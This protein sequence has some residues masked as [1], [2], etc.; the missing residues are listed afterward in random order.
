MFKIIV[1]EN[2]DELSEK[3]FEVMKE[4]ITSSPI[5]FWVWRQAPARS[6]CTRI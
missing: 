2:Y 4:V 1:T 5:R 6:V 3:A